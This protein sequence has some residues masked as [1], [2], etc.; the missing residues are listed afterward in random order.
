MVTKAELEEYCDELEEAIEEAYQ[1]LEGNDHERA[2]EIL[3]EYMGAQEDE[4]EDETA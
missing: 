4:G 1:A 2:Q 3:R